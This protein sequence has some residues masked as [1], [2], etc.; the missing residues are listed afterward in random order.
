MT[1]AYQ[2]RPIYFEANH[3]QHPETIRYLFR[4]DRYHLALHQR[5]VRWS[6]KNSGTSNKDSLGIQRAQVQLEWL[7]T[8]SNITVSGGV[9]GK[10]KV[11]YF[12]GNQIDHWY[13]NIPTYAKVKYQEIYPGIDLIFY[14]NHQNLLEYDFMLAPG[15][16][17]S[18][19]AFRYRGMDHWWIDEEGNLQLKIGEEL[20]TQ[21][22]PIVYQ[23]IDGER[24]R[25]GG[26]YRIEANGQ[27]GF[28]I[29]A[30]DSDYP[31]IIDPVIRY[32]TFLG[33]ALGDY[34]MAIDVDELGQAYVTGVSFSADFPTD[35]AFQNTLSGDAD[36][37]VT[38]LD[39]AGQVLYSTYIGG[40][41]ADSGA[42]IVVGDDQSVYITGYTN[43]R[44][45]PL[46]AE[47]D[48]TLGGINDAFVT[49]LHPDGN[50][51]LF[52]TYLGGSG[53]DFGHGI[54]LN[55]GNDAYVTGYTASED[56]PTQNPIQASFGGGTGDA[57]ISQIRS[58][59]SALLYSTYLGGSRNDCYISNGA[60]NGLTEINCR[61]AIHSDS[62]I[63]IAGTTNSQD[64][65]TQNPLS[66]NLSGNR[67]AFVSRISADGSTFIYSTY[68]G[69][70]S[71]ERTYDIA[72]NENGEAYFV[73]LTNSDDLPLGAAPVQ[74]ALGGSSDGFIAGLS[75]D[76][77][78]LVAG[79]YLGGSSTDFCRAI[80]I[81]T[82]GNP[83]LT[84]FTQSTD[85]P[86]MA[87]LQGY[88]DNGDAFVTTLNAGANTFLFSTYLG[89][90][91]AE[92][93]R[94]IASD[95][96]NSL[97]ITGSTASTDFPILAPFQADWAGGEADA[98]VTKL[99]AD[100]TVY[101]FEY[102]AKV[103]CGMQE[104][105]ADLRLARGL[106]ATTINIHSPGLTRA[107]F[108]KKLAL[109]YPPGGQLPGAILPIATDT[110]R[111][112]QALAV[113]CMDIRERVFPNGFPTPYIEGF[114]VVQSTQALDLTAVYTTT[115]LNANG[116]VD[117]HSSIDV[118]QIPERDRRVDLSIQKAALPFC[119]LINDEIN[120][121]LVL[122]E[123]RVTNEGTNEAFNVEVI[124]ELTRPGDPT[125]ALVLVA[126]SPIEVL[127][128][129]MANIISQT[130]LESML[131]FD[132]SSIPAGDF[133]TIRFWALTFSLSFDQPQLLINRAAVGADQSDLDNLDNSTTIITN[134]N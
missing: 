86:L 28:S 8:S 119:F 65:P 124:D 31:I 39:A 2:K 99:G 115:A 82:L 21:E 7:N 131:Q 34:G 114:V 43:S 113:D 75:A 4:G 38:K 85:F 68:Y 33:G 15:T 98:F 134:L 117:D 30:Y 89:G 10:A 73:G 44:D 100:T 106:Y 84:G 91:L 77:S 49:K 60:L 74:N 79:T 26:E 53:A 36:V 14:G 27:M 62:T 6:L 107:Q 71:N 13:P 18:V 51:L 50:A 41:Q 78:S 81:D 130:G 37:L 23:K 47:L 32:S 25:I 101:D 64:F 95:L 72:L 127:P 128:A 66:P 120:Y 105:P 132:I 56:F 97:Y 5:E 17:P 58:D 109:T 1:D 90:G 116:Q 125:Q 122:Y 123:I 61:I 54:D 16:D 129:G 133:A 55:A 126:P 104:D 3:G 108:F 92:S 87:P 63:S 24:Q 42:D 12:K 20:F 69:G 52:S 29:P 9:P 96:Y 70:T 76:G 121:C 35:A 19:I 103:V 93:G 48:G 102:V 110:L 59:G 57:F 83:S 80:T 11:H 94:G 46:Q 22:A 111:E 40:A 45:Y 88:Q 112:D 67:D 118:E